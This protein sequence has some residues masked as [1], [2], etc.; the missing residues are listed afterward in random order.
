MLV[1]TE[2]NLICRQHYTVRLHTLLKIYSKQSG[3]KVY[4]NFLQ[5]FLP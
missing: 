4:E 1:A 3:K 5:N 2:M